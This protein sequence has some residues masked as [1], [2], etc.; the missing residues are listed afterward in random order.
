M[1]PIR[2]QDVKHALAGEHN[3]GLFQCCRICVL[4]NL[5]LLLKLDKFAIL[6][7]AIV[8]PIKKAV[9]RRGNSLF[10]YINEIIGYRLFEGSGSFPRNPPI[11][12]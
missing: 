8:I 5:N 12:A 11:Q 9:F 3:R 4:K 1:V 2:L 6:I 10:F 7:A